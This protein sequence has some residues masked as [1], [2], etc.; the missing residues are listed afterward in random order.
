[1]RI[2]NKNPFLGVL[3]DIV[4]IQL[5]FERPIVSGIT[6]GLL[7]KRTVLCCIMQEYIGMGAPEVAAEILG[8]R[9]DQF[10]Q[11]IQTFLAIITIIIGVWRH[12]DCLSQFVTITRTICLSVR[13]KLPQAHYGRSL[14][15]H[16]KSEP[17]KFIVRNYFQTSSYLKSH[18]ANGMKLN[19]S[20]SPIDTN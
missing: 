12:L 17:R 20:A 16:F 7:R 1:M 2:N 11:K 19:I 18:L 9:K 13:I 8:K 10:V 4:I 5:I 6:P 14:E 15:E 3:S